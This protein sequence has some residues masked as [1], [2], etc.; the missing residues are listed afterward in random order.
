M[1][2]GNQEAALVESAERLF[3]RQGFGATGARQIAGDAGVPHGSFTN[4][5]RSKD[6][7]GAAALDRYYARLDAT[8]RETLDD[9]SQDPG[10]RLLRYFALI[11]TRLD[12][13]GWTQGCLIPD[14]ATEATAYGDALRVKLVGL[15]EAQTRAFETVVQAAASDAAADDLAGFI[16]AAWHGTLLR[17]KVERTPL[18]VDRFCRVLEGLIRRGWTAR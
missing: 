15:L 5:F 8:M 17:M 9:P 7:L 4:H 14:M 1:G 10:D 3:H 6:A 12:D 16:V 18:A 13:A 2:K 11:R